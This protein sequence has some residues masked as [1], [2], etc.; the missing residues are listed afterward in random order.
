MSKD[1]INEALEL[2]RETEKR[3]RDRTRKFTSD[4]IRAAVGVSGRT[5]MPANL[6]G[7]EEALEIDRKLRRNGM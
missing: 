6:P 2:T 1:W 3:E 5:R 4:D 7:L